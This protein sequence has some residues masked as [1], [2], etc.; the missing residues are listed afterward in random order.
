VGSVEQKIIELAKQGLG[1][2]TILKKLGDEATDWQVRAVLA[3]LRSTVE[4]LDEKEREVLSKNICPSNF[5]IVANL[6]PIELRL[7]RN[8]KILPTERSSTKAIFVGD[9]QAPFVDE[10]AID[11]TC[12]IIS[13]ES[14]DILAH[15][16]DMVD[17]YSI[18]RFDKDP[19]RRLLLQDEIEAGA[20]TL[21]QFDQAV[22][23]KTRKLLFRGNHEQRLETYIKTNAPALAGL[24]HLQIQNLFGLKDLGWE[25]I[26][27]DLELFPDFLV[28]HGDIIRQQAGY[29]ARGEMDRA[30]MSGI[31]GHSHRQ[32]L[33]SYTPRRAFL[34]EEQA[35]FWVENACLCAMTQEYTRGNGNWQQGFTIIHAYDGGKILVPEFV[36]I[37]HGR[38]VHKGKLYK[39]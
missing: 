27:Q 11:V 29:T 23:Q 15:L 12:Q 10:R 38:A 24:E 17:F 34:H 25:Y 16:G 26:T 37:V 30:W 33:Y 36:H 9:T 2:P 19:T 31:S 4:N 3:D 1:R 13:D 6:Q 39:G 5:D 14:P 8:R 7:P 18:S 32:A 21:G 28:K 20:Y 22:P 35:P